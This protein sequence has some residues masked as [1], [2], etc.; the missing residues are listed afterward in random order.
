MRYVAARLRAESENRAYRFY[1][2]DTL[3]M[4]AENAGSEQ[5]RYP[6]QRL[7]DII[8]SPETDEEEDP[9]SCVEIVSDMWAKINGKGADD[10]TT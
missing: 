9:R 4:I 8:L 10:V 7:A 2:S 5:T 6:A 3:K 1:V